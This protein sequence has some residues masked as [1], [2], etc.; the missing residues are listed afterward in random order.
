M[1][2]AW[3]Q[4]WVKELFSSPQALFCNITSLKKSVVLFS[5]WKAKH[6]QRRIQGH[7]SQKD[8]PSVKKYT[9]KWVGTDCFRLWSRTMII[10]SFQHIHKTQAKHK[11]HSFAWHTVQANLYNNGTIMVCG[12]VCKMAFLPLQK[13]LSKVLMFWKFL[14][15]HNSKK[16]ISHSF[17][18]IIRMTQARI[19]FS[20]FGG[21]TY[22]WKT[23]V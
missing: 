10:P 11:W 9:N 3:S 2:L 21:I 6:M 23:V 4:E 16:V 22:E 1:F 14:T 15:I 12:C 19:Q 18:L 5:H 20:P 13:T 7:H 17:S 8:W